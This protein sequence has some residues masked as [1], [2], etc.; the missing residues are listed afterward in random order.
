MKQLYFLV[1]LLAFSFTNA[2]IV[3]IPDYYFKQAL[4]ANALGNV[5]AEAKDLAGNPITVDANS[6]GTIELSEAQNV[7]WLTIYT[8]LSMENTIHDFTGIEAFSN[9][10][11]FKCPGHNIPN[12][13]FS[14]LPQLEEL[15]LGQ[16]NIVNLNL[17]GLVNLHVLDVSGEYG[18]G[19]LTNLD[20]TGLGGLKK[21]YCSANE[22]TS[23]NF[24]S[25]PLLEELECRYNLLTA[26]DFSG[27]AHIKYINCANNDITSI[28]VA[29]LPT[30]EILH[31]YDNNLT[32]ID[33]SGLPNLQEFACGQ[34]QLP[35]LDI[36]GS[37]ALLNLSCGYNNIV[38]LDVSAQTG[39]EY[40]FCDYN[41][42]TTLDVTGHADLLRLDCENNLLTSLTV[43]GCENLYELNCDHNAL[44]T[45]DLS[46]CKTSYRLSCCY[47][48]LTSLFL[49]NG[50][51]NTF[52]THFNNN[53]DLTY[54]CADEFEIDSLYSRMYLEA[55]YPEPET[56]SVN[57]YC[58]FVPGGNFYVLHGNTNF[59]ADGDGCE[60][61]DMA[62]PALNLHITNGTLSGN[63]HADNSGTYDIP[64]QAGI[65]TVTPQ[66]ENPDYFIVSPASFVVDFP[67][68]PSP[69][70][71]N[72]CLIFNG[73]HQDL[74]VVVLPLGPARPG[75]DSHYKI[76][77]KNKG[78]TVESGT[79][80]FA[81]EYD[82][83]NF[84]SA[85]PIAD[86]QTENVLSWNY[87]DLQP[88]ESRTI[89]VTLNANSP[90][91][92]PAVNI[93]DQLN[94]QATINDFISDETPTDNIFGFKQTVVGSLDPNDKTCLEGQAV[95]PEIGGNYVHYVIRFEN[96]GN[97]PAENVVVRD[98]IDT[99]KFDAGSLIPI[100]SSHPFVTRINNNVAEFIFEG[101]N[102]PFDDATND[103]Y[104]IFKIKTLPTLV[105]GDTFSNSAR[106]FFDYNLPVVTNTATTAIQSL[107]NP[108]FEFSNYFTIF[109]NPVQSILNI[110]PRT[111]IALQ[112]VLVYN[113]IGQLVMT[114]IAPDTAIEVG[115]LPPGVYF[116]KAA[117][118]NGTGVSPFIKK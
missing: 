24:S 25:T 27:L 88:F 42:L 67:T 108:D 31:C 68:A 30:I 2:Q 46:D 11:Y 28:D 62:Y 41:Q 57:S 64:V 71:Q 7:S 65:H 36:S 102:L 26:L 74:E 75:F 106:I 22:L 105:L 107:G 59:D 47:N 113:A 52:Y 1:V 50:S 84:V 91:E 100:G 48:N 44:T 87:A 10:K 56:V 83:M 45:L 99:N 37:T 17:S 35:S 72:F 81:F 114:V 15:H 18:I 8:T 9:L 20:L 97:Y 6:N 49:K 111:E 32:A 13:N 73:P 34:N 21:L 61:T 53:Y 103:G 14:M 98:Q 23:L 109:P 76:I 94:F 33:V 78:T 115:T 63:F 85:A 101:I 39:L 118:A 66:L 58:S 70:V 60:P 40:L 80:L 54:I 79:L 77:Y 29:N 110:M 89:D 5:H 69:L 96:T 116:L 3:N 55:M 82:K 43:T 38:S 19:P 4:T 90:S 93:G 51:A 95:G 92:T 86:S 104:I 16:N 12:A 112:S 117:T